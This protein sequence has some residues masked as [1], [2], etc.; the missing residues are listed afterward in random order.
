MIRRCAPTDPHA[1][2]L[3][4]E[5]SDHYRNAYGTS[6]VT[7]SDID[8]ALVAFHGSAPVAIVGWAAINAETVHLRRLYVVPT[9]R[10]GGLSIEVVRAALA[11]ASSAGYRQAVWDTGADLPEVLATSTRLGAAP[12]NSFGAQAQSPLTRCFAMD[13]DRRTIKAAALPPD[14]AR[15]SRNGHVTSGPHERVQQ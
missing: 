2:L 13:L 14:G 1:R 3:L 9:A 4:G 6:D 8:V 7:I 12:V 11:D 10:G 5:L 15:V